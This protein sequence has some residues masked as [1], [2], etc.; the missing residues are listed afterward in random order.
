MHFRGAE[1]SLGANVVQVCSLV[2]HRLQLEQKLLKA[3]TRGKK[4]EQSAGGRV[5]MG[6]HSRLTRRKPARKV[7]EMA[8]TQ[9]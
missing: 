1:Q 6:G 9:G 3:R 8:V 4:L 2:G 7:S 5:G